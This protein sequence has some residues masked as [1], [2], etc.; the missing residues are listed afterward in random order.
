MGKFWLACY[1][2]LKAMG[3]WDGCVCAIVSGMVLLFITTLLFLV[4][5]MRAL[6]GL[7]RWLERGGKAKD[8]DTQP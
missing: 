7:A 4:S 8:S 1:Q 2:S 6:I 5:C 3:I